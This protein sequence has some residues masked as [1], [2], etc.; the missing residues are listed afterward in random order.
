MPAPRPRRGHSSAL[1]DG[2]LEFV[3]YAADFR[4]QC[5]RC[6]AAEREQRVPAFDH[7]RDCGC[8]QLGPLMGFHTDGTP[9]TSA[10]AGPEDREAAW[11]QHG[12]GIL[13]RRRRLGLPGSLWAEQVYG[14]PTL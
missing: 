1:V 9:C 2:G 8:D 7:H 14:E 6:R 12:A 11:A 5:A 3:V 13:A 10:Y 4:R